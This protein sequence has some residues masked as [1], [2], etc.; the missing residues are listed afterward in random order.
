VNDCIFCRIVSGAFTSATIYEDTDYKVILDRFPASRGHTLIIPK[1]HYD[2]MFSAPEDV[3]AGAY[4][5]SV[6]V[7]DHLRKTLGFS[8]MNVVQNN[9]ELAG[10]TVNHFHIHLIPRYKG[11]SPAVAW[12]PGDVTEAELMEI[13]H[14]LTET[15]IQ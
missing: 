4:K 12:K 9:G 5:L 11:D 6:K 7:A 8:D 1:K 10:Q 15:K 13:R 2:N 3:I 14:L